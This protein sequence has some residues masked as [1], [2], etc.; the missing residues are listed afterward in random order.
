MF[1]W[2]FNNH[3][4]SLHRKCEE[5]QLY[6]NDDKQLWEHREIEHPT[7]TDTQVQAEPQVSLDPVTL[8]TSRQDCQVKCTYCD[9]HFSS[10][11]KCN[12]HINRR[13]KK[14]ACPK[15]EKHFGKQV[16][17]DNHFRDV[18]K[19]TCSL[20]RCSVSKYNELELHEHMRLHHQPDFVFRCNKCVKVFRTRPQLLVS[21]AFTST[22]SSLSK[23]TKSR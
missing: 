8:D 10:V 16:D 1:P 11:A 17:C 3:L 19:F 20:K 15:G 21:K 22:G 7:A 12:M 14:V 2:Y 5:C 4:D 23:P 9:R 18:H 13:H 6:L